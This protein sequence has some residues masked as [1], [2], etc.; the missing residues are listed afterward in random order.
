MSLL[1]DPKIQIQNIE[2]CAFSFHL[3]P[4]FYFCSLSVHFSP[5]LSV[6]LSSLTKSLSQESGKA[7]KKASCVN[8]CQVSSSGWL[9]WVCG[10]PFIYQWLNSIKQTIY[11]R[12]ETAVLSDQRIYHSWETHRCSYL[13]SIA[14]VA[15][16]WWRI[17]PSH[18]STVAGSSAGSHTGYCTNKL[19]STV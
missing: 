16:R 2:F 14:S 10:S 18:P 8:S 1:C 11:E 15:H 9:K 3:Q 13:S 12:G 4:E 6:F 17:A 7:R 5:S 19:T